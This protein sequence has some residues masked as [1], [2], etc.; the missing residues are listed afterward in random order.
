MT[1]PGLQW[2][3]E[4]HQEG[5]GLVAVTRADW[6]WDRLPVEGVVRVVMQ[7]GPYTHRLFGMDNYWLIEAL[8][9]YGLYNDPDN[10][11]WYA[12]EQALAYAWPT[13]ELHV[14][15]ADA[16]PPCGVHTLRGIMLPDDLAREYG[17]L[18]PS[19]HSPPRPPR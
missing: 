4:Y 18:G 3:V 17:I 7:H 1:R 16:D 8:A 5:V 2:R 9:I 12:G 14:R 11:D 6:A 10:H 19:D 13:P 15:L